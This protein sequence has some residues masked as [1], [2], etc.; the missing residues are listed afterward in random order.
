[1]NIKFVLILILIFVYHFLKAQ[2]IKWEEINK[3]WFLNSAGY[4]AEDRT[5][6]MLYYKLNGYKLMLSTDN[7]FKMYFPLD[8]VMEGTYKIDKSNYTI[9]FLTKDNRK[10]TY[11]ISQFNNKHL[12]LIAPESTHWAFHLD[13]TSDK[14]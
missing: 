13:L 5:L 10:M 8:T 9:T 2:Q 11:T 4:P 3:E 12:V 14:H 7:T 1:M 6:D